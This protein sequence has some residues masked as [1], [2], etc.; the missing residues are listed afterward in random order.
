MVFESSWAERFFAH[1][2]LLAQ[3]H[4]WHQ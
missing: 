1:T 3:T 2:Q 4:T